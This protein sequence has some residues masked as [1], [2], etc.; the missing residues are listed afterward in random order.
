MVFTAGERVR[1]RG[2]M[3]L[4]KPPSTRQTATLATMLL[5]G[6]SITLIT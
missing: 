2:S 1:R 6:S 3:P 5:A 4:K